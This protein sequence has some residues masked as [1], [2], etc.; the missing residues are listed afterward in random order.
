LEPKANGVDL[1]IRVVEKT[2]SDLNFGFHYDS[3]MESAVL[4][5][6]TLRNKFIMGSKLS[7]SMELSENS[8]H[9]ISYFI[10]TG[11]KPGFGFGI[12]HAGKE[13]RVPI[14]N[15]TEK[16]AIYNYSTSLSNFDIQTIF[17]NSFTVGG[18]LE[19]NYVKLEPDI[20]I[21]NMPNAEGEYQLFSY[22]GYC[23]VNTYD[24]ITYPRKG[25]VLN[26]E[27]KRMFE[28]Y[29]SMEENHD[30]IS[31][32]LMRCTAVD[33]LINNVVYEETVYLGTIKG[34]FVPSDS[35]F[36]L[37]G[38]Y[39]PEHSLIPFVGTEFMSLICTEVAMMSSALRW[40]LM[41][42]LYVTAKVNWAYTSDYDGGVVKKGQNHHGYGASIGLMTPIGPVE[43]TAS[44]GNDKNETLI[45]SS[46]GFYF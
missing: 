31:I 17:S 14:Y 43:V 3:D 33:K 8:A 11:W 41:N 38:H 6:A 24:R 46:I 10:H 4:L 35:Y 16:I 37:G 12:S 13:F 25:V 34:E 45:S 27:L 20:I 39:E 15:G 5:N 40:E 29:H 28:L 22:R 19:L 1:Y 2:A 26:V 18:G 36:Y 9:E 23:Q 44:R 30:P 21:P 32:F 7:L 42:D